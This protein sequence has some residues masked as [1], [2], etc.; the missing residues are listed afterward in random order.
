MQL[1]DTLGLSPGKIPLRCSSCISRS[2]KCTLLNT[3]LKAESRGE[4]L[5]DTTVARLGQ[6]VK[7]E[8]AKKIVSGAKDLETHGT[9]GQSTRRRSG[10]TVQDETAPG[11]R[12]VT[13]CHRA[14]NRC[15][16]TRAR[17]A[18]RADAG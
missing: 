3:P 7:F 11:L 2:R 5:V 16:F 4:T 15:S 12:R 17:N 6:L 18:G 10:K 9:H 8:G 13:E 1:S 14:S